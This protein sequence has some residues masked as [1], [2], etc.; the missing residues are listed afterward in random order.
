[1]EPTHSEYIH[2]HFTTDANKVR[3][4]DIGNKYARNDPELIQ[5]LETKVIPILNL[6]DRLSEV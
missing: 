3:V 5:Q 6:E 4:L 1:M 2:L